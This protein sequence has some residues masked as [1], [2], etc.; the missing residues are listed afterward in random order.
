MEKRCPICA[1][2]RDLGDK[3]SAD[4]AQVLVPSEESPKRSNTL[5]GNIE[6]AFCLAYER[7]ASLDEPDQWVPCDEHIRALEHVRKAGL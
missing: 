3:L 7:G 5:C 2:L 1:T 4:I 6:R